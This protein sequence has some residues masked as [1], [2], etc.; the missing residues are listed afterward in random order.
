MFQQDIKIGSRLQIKSHGK[1]IIGEVLSCSFGYDFTVSP[2]VYNSAYI[3]LLSDD[4]QVYYWKSDIDGGSIE[5]L[6]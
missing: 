6:S 5:V 3:E 2:P 1:T 4:N